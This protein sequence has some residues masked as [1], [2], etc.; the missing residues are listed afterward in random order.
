Q[1]VPIAARWLV[2]AHV[3]FVIAVVIAGHD[4]VSGAAPPHAEAGEERRAR[5]EDR[6][7]ACR[8]IVDAEAGDLS[9]AESCPPI[10]VL[11][12]PPRVA[13]IIAALCVLDF[14]I[15]QLPED[16]S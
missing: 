4:H 15:S 1:D 12:A 3:G 6:P 2:D 11:P 9:A 8:L 13:L 5:L 10:G 7:R 16:V 14:R